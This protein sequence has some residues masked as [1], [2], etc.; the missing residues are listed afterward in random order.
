M[1]AGPTQS[2]K[3][4][5]LLKES[6]G[7]LA[8]RD[9][10]SP[11]LEAELLLAAALGVRRIDLYLQFDKVLAAN[12]V[13]TF[14]GFVRQRLA[15]RPSQYI[16]GEAAFRLL[17]LH[18]DDH[19]LVPRPETELLVE[20]ALI[21]LRDAPDGQVL[22]LGCGSGAIAISI[23]HERD[24]VSLVASDL[25]P[26]ALAV[27]RRN[28]RRHELEG[29]IRFV[30]GDLCAPFDPGAPFVAVLCNPPY[31]ASG[32]L[33]GLQPEVRDHEPRLALDGGADGLDVIRRLVDTIGAHLCPGGGLFVEVGAGQADEVAQLLHVAGFAEPIRIVPDLAGI[34][35]LVIGHT[36]TD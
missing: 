5:D 14:R 35:R 7:F 10:D 16:T 28:A 3:L 31:I 25:S 21:F 30:C 18:V 23:A 34:P 20:E 4:L 36:P 11:R 33:A 24:G 8:G 22:D 6:S 1:S 26:A 17:D 27:A 15:G 12:E 19:V 9:L 13:E 2:W 32:D 29:R